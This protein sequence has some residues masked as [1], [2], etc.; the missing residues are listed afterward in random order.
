M[1]HRKEEYDAAGHEVTIQQ[2][3]GPDSPSGATE[4]SA[5]IDGKAAY[6]DDALE[7]VPIDV[8]GLDKWDAIKRLMAFMADNDVY[9]CKKCNTFYDCNDSS[10]TGFAGHQCGDCARG[11]ARCPDNPD[12][13]GHEDE[14]LNPSQ[15]HNAR[16]PTKYKCEHCGRT[17]Q[18]TPTG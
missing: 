17:R 5:W 4:P 14:C 10:G 8:S 9:F 1:A 18:T 12:G 6:T 16:V 7:Y 13:D 3:R 11:A 2:V 15:K